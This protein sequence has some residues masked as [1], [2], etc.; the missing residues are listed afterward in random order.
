MYSIT[1][2]ITNQIL[3][4]Y[5]LSYVIENELQ[6]LFRSQ[7]F[8]DDVQKRLSDPMERVTFNYIISN[9]LSLN[10]KYIPQSEDPYQAFLEKKP[11][12]TVRRVG[13]DGRMVKKDEPKRFGGIGA[14]G[15]L[16]PHS[17]TLTPK[18]SA[19]SRITITEPVMKPSKLTYTDCRTISLNDVRMLRSPLANETLPP[20]QKFLF[21]MSRPEAMS[22][23]IG[24]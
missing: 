18:N 12:D 1:I 13:S 11:Q 9:P 2:D 4:A 23:V 17:T 24:G 20:L 8:Q 19:A 7:L 15:G 21:V 22:G 5:K 14:W 16:P 10:D 6:R 3:G